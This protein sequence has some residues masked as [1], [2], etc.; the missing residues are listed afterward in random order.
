MGGVGWG[1]VAVVAASVVVCGWWE[2]ISDLHCAPSDACGG[3]LPA[4]VVLTAGGCAVLMCRS[5]GRDSGRARSRSPSRRDKD[6]GRD[7]D[8]CV[9]L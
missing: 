4:S 1:G 8:R 2:G 5:R 9:L 3:L 6:T 7:K